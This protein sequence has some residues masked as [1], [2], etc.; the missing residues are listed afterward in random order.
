MQPED[1]LIIIG[2][3]GYGFFKAKGYLDHIIDYSEVSNVDF[4]YL[5]ILPVTQVIMNKYIDGSF[6]KVNLAYTK[7]INSLT[8]EPII[9]QILPFSKKLF[10]NSQ[11]TRR[12]DETVLTDKNQII[13]YEPSKREI[14]KSITSTFITTIIYASIIESKVCE[15]GSRRNAMDTA[16]KNAEQ[17][18]D[19]LT[20]EFN[21]QR[22]ENITQEINEIVAGANANEN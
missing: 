21:R 1:Q 20:L 6:K 5:E 19:D 14:A 13:E 12:T 18:I 4:D 10:Q 15:N 2:K 17:L 9:L 8:F 22:Q 7:F 11:S 16:N 3:R